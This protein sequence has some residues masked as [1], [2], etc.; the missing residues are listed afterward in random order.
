MCIVPVVGAQSS[1][2][3]RY[4]VLYRSDLHVSIIF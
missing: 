4:L 3:R 2:R 1:A